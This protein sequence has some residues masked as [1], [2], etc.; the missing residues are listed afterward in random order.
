MEEVRKIIKWFS[1]LDVETC[2]EIGV[3]LSIFLRDFKGI[4]ERKGEQWCRIRPCRT[5]Q[6]ARGLCA[7]HYRKL[8]KIANHRKI[9]W[10]SLARM[11]LCKF[12]SKEL[13]IS[14]EASTPRKNDPLR[15]LLKKHPT[16]PC[17]N[18]TNQ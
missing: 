18:Q 10:I 9:G 13:N 15:I 5:H 11:G 8:K 3:S 7:S 4:K 16:T 17:P 2:Q 12:S 6:Y 14:Y 1:G